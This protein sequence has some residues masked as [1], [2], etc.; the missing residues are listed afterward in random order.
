MKRLEMDKVAAKTGAYFKKGLEALKAKYPDK[1]TDVRGKGLIL[2]LELA[3]AGGSLVPAALKKGFIINCTAGNVLRFVPP[4][5]IAEKDID[6]LL[7]VLDE[8]LADF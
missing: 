6:G 7:S 2:G 5:I 8:L 1:V 3:K 4:L